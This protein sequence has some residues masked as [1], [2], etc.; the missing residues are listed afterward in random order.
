MELKFQ[1]K[2]QV[3]PGSATSHLCLAKHSIHIYLH[4]SSTFGFHDAMRLIVAA[5]EL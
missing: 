1:G 2:K 4:C 5:E 3:S